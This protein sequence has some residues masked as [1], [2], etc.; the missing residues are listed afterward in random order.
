MKKNLILR[1]MAALLMAVLLLSSCSSPL[2]T[3]E[4]TTE[5]ETEDPNVGRYYIGAAESGGQGLELSDE[6]IEAMYLRLKDDGELVMQMNEDKYS[7]SWKV[8]KGALTLKFDSDEFEE[9]EYQGSIADGVIDIEIDDVHMV[10]VKG[11]NAAKEYAKEHPGTQAETTEAPTEPTTEEPTTEEPTTTAEATTA[12]EETTKEFYYSVYYVVV[13]NGWHP[14]KA[15]LKNHY[16]AFPSDGTDATP[17]VNGQTSKVPWTLS[18]GELKLTIGGQTYLTDYEEPRIMIIA[19]N[20]RALFVF[21]MSF[22]EDDWDDLFAGQ[23]STEEPTEADTTPAEAA[24]F[25]VSE[26]LLCDRDGIKVTAIGVVKDNWYGTGIEIRV[27]NTTDKDIYVGSDSASVNGAML[28]EDFYCRAEAG[29]TETD[30]LY[31][32]EDLLAAYSIGKV[33]YVDLCLRA[34]DRSDYHT[35]FEETKPARIKTSLYGSEDKPQLPADSILMFDDKGVQIYFVHTAFN[36]YEELYSRLYVVNNTGKRIIFDYDDMYIND[37]EVDAF[38]YET[39]DVG[40]VL[41]SDMEYDDDS[42]EALN[43]TS[44]DDLKSAGFT[45]VIIDDET[46]DDIVETG[47]ITIEYTD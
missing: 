16:I 34:V 31:L 27:E 25:S 8:R 45:F 39:I 11:K 41:L 6:M 1:I 29:K 4:A 24:A 15:D 17:L 20:M 12:P 30:V 47:L 9:D 21:G 40:C 14:E 13:Y 10:F 2:P 22:A 3:K 18:N 23:E 28:N 32:D 44:I 43:L 35:I 36:D 5:E 7:G 46:Y 42:V 33:G 37:T 38:I 19:D 26:Q